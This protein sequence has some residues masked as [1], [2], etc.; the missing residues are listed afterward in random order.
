MDYTQVKNDAD[1]AN[2]AP[3]LIRSRDLYP[4][5]WDLKRFPQ[6]VWHQPADGLRKGEKPK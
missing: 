6:N 2:I 1:Y 4:N 5:L 3:T